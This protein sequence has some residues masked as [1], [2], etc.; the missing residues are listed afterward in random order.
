MRPLSLYFHLPF[1]RTRCGYCGFFSGV[2]L[3]LRESYLAALLRAVKTAPVEGCTAVTVYFGGGTPTLLGEGLCTVLQA[4]RQR[5]PIADDAEITV[6][7]NPGT[8]SPALLGALRAAGFN[9]ISFGL[10]DC[11]DAMLR[12][13]GRSHTAQEGEQAV[14]MAKKAGFENISVDFML[15][16]PGQT[17]AAA[18]ALARYG[19]ALDIPHISSYLLRIEPGTPFEKAGMADSC[20]DDDTAADCYLAFYEELVRGG[21][22]HYEISNAARPGFQSRHNSRYW[23][24]GEYLGIGPSAHSFFGGRRFFFPKIITAFLSADSPWSLCCDDGQGGGPQERMMLALRLQEGLYLPDMQYSPEEEALMRKKA[25][26]LEKAGLLRITQDR[27]SLTER[28]FL[29]SNSVIA[30]LV[31]D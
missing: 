14:R 31:P 13:L 28:G 23:Q 9:R 12:L 8:V 17:P 6:E 19:M 2:D 16:T 1:C 22:L 7:A 10:Q 21:Y 29:L 30:A 4:V 24:L 26:P 3:S 20:P 25:A 27:L 11:D 5:L 18:A 15:A